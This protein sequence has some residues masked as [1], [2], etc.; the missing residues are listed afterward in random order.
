MDIKDSQSQLEREPPFHTPERSD[1]FIA[2][3]NA[4]KWHRMPHSK[5]GSFSREEMEQEPPGHAIRLNQA[6]V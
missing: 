6:M 2:Y 4:E 1:D 3:N 5:V